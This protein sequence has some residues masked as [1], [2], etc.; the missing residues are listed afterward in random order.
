ML[1]DNDIYRSASGSGK[2]T[3][4]Y[5]LLLRRY[6]TYRNNVK[7]RKWPC[8]HCQENPRCL[9]VKV[10]VGTLFIRRHKQAVP[11]QALEQCSLTS[12][13]DTM[14][15]LE[16]AR[17]ID[18]YSVQGSA[19]PALLVLSTFPNQGWHDKGRHESSRRGTKG[20]TNN[21]NMPPRSR[22]TGM[23]AGVRD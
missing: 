1:V 6:I 16:P 4:K 10:R 8:L 11:N 5:A 2:T 15:L 9:R 18:H 14:I 3:S 12:G 17:P 7:A 21:K 19:T 22:N 20:N 13:N 23:S